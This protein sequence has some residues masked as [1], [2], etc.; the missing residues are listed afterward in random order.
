MQAFLVEVNYGAQVFLVDLQEL[1][2]GTL[3]P[4]LPPWCQHPPP[5][6]LPFLRANRRNVACKRRWPV[7]GT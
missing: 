5:E 4:L 2:N 1:Y 3:F 6:P 7:S